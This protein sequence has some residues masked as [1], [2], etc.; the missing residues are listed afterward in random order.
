ML[1]VLK[2]SEKDARMEDGQMAKVSKM[3]EAAEYLSNHKSSKFNFIINPRNLS[4][5]VFYPFL[6][7]VLSGSLSF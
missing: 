3:R 4:G 5:I 1:L 2:E 7:P 6:M